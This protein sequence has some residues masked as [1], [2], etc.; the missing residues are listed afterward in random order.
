MRFPLTTD[1]PLPS[2]VLSSLTEGSKC[3]AS[4]AREA[5]IND[6]EFVSS[7]DRE[8]AS[9][10]PRRHEGILL[11]F[12]KSIK[13]PASDSTFSLALIVDIIKLS[14]IGNLCYT[15]AGITTATVKVVTLPYSFD[16][17]TDKSTGVSKTMIAQISQYPP[18]NFDT[19]ANLIS[20]ESFNESFT[21]NFRY[22]NESTSITAGTRN[23][24]WKEFTSS[25]K[26]NQSR[27][28]KRTKTKPLFQSYK[29]SYPH[30][31]RASLRS[32][33]NILMGN[34]PRRVMQLAREHINY[35]SRVTS[36]RNTAASVKLTCSTQ[37]VVSSQ[38]PANLAG[39]ISSVFIDYGSRLMI[40]AFAKRSSSNEEGTCLSKRDV[41]A[42]HSTLVK[43]RGI[44]PDD[45]LEVRP[46]KSISSV[47]QSIIKSY[48]RHDFR[49]N[50]AT[51][52]LSLKSD[53][54]D[55]LQI[56]VN[57]LFATSK[58][59][60]FT[61]QVN[62]LSTLSQMKKLSYA[63]TNDSSAH[64]VRMST[65]DVKRWYLGGIC[66]IT[67]PEGSTIGL[68][69]E[70]TLFAK[71]SPSG[72]VLTPYL[73]SSFGKISKTLVYF[74]YLETLPFVLA[75][76]AQIDAQTLVALRNGRPRL[77]S[78][79]EVDL[80]LPTNACLFSASV[81][82][83]PFLNHNNPTRLLTA[84]NMQKQAI[85][86][87]TPTPP[88][89]GTGFE[90]T[91][92]T[93]S[94][95][96]ITAD[97]PCIVMYADSSEVMVYQL[98]SNTY[99]KYT[100]PNPSGS[101]QNTCQRLRCIVHSE[102]ALKRGDI[103]AECQSSAQGELSLGC[104]LFVAFVCWK[105]LNFED[106]IAISEDV[107][108]NGNFQSIHIYELT[109]TLNRTAE[110]YEVLTNS[111]ECASTREKRHLEATG[112]PKI[113]ADVES[114][115]ILIGKN[116]IPYC[117]L[118]IRRSNVSL[119][120]PVTIGQA[121]I[122]EVNTVD[123][124]LPPKA[125]VYHSYPNRIVLTHA[126]AIRR[127]WKFF[128][129]YYLSS[130]ASSSDFP[131][132][133]IS[134]S[135]Q[136]GGQITLIFN[137][138]CHQINDIPSLTSPSA[139]TRCY[140]SKRKLE[141]SYKQPEIK[142]KLLVT[143]S[144][145]VGDKLCGRHGNKG[146]ISSI[147]PREDMPYTRSGTLVD[148]IMNPLSI[149]SRMNYGQVLESQIGLISMK[150]SSEFKALLRIYNQTSDLSILVK[151]A[152]PKLKEFLPTHPFELIDNQSILMLVKECAE[153]VKFSCPPFSKM[154]QSRFD[155]LFNRVRLTN[156][157]RQ[158]QLYDGCTGKPFD[159]KSTAGVLY[160]F[161]LNHMVEDKI[162]ARSTGPYSAVMQQPLGG[163][164]HRG[165]QRLGEM[166]M[167]ALQSHGAPHLIKEAL[168]LR[169]DDI[170][171]RKSYQ[172]KLGTKLPYQCS[173]SESFRVLTRE[174]NSLGLS[175]NIDFD[176]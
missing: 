58:M 61:D 103:I 52:S 124:P 30:A 141:S 118:A 54:Y 66:P 80:W 90:R 146:V 69:N 125:N 160:M 42:L 172:G 119:R 18:V 62:A 64:S 2:E 109:T 23:Y 95:Q 92:M 12:R 137:S 38:T 37:G 33:V 114:G 104:N 126:R 8:V 139:K 86:L 76:Y 35:S 147:V 83:I 60:Q 93:Q 88:I 107:V 41:I 132:W 20:F 151:Q 116:F 163:R 134:N 9:L 149:T 105:G 135:S 98:P 11:E 102:Q 158:V 68:I 175:V 157:L 121:T 3:S 46:I 4:P 99:K 25:L 169:C 111:P 84:S 59:A 1:I 143:R 50:L 13:L 122:M 57:K 162:H 22:V 112:L 10:F 21:L 74:S 153:A 128:I 159:F 32:L 45:I 129:S 14:S 28:F 71:V 155:S 17:Y 165:G 97:E 6:R 140:I 56:R 142:V 144:L 85:P 5:E 113:G 75:P 167:W 120:L 148:V 96:N 133:L 170:I 174:F 131:K 49:F 39:I 72:E 130:E 94:N 127:I 55:S 70:L 173:W 19:K 63:L 79:N 106:S 110:G 156:P 168:S 161:K 24:S 65:R 87:Q 152:V 34:R 108:A 164:S 36:S 82:L 101:N 15:I 115:D 29:G 166:E 16:V 73:K 43:R 40:N 47:L 176:R 27:L 78:P 31:S 100:L 138:F 123:L 48:L 51:L 77:C 154:K 117:R 44:S 150:L 171:A 7:F 136:H 145:Q 81:N 67:S 89:V 26:I 53:L 91:V